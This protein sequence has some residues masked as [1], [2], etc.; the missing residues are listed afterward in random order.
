MAAFEEFKK[1]LD[2]LWSQGHLPEAKYQEM[3][4]KHLK[5]YNQLG[6]QADEVFLDL[7]KTQDEFRRY[8]QSHDNYD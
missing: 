2:E 7:Q 4:R 6:G 3:Q 8:K 1:E 5:P